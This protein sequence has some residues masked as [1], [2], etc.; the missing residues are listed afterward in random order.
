MAK[1]DLKLF[2]LRTVPEIGVW[3][4]AFFLF[5]MFYAAT[6]DGYVIT[7]YYTNLFNEHYAELIFIGWSWLTYTLN[8]LT[9]F[10]K[11]VVEAPYAP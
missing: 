10:I 3:A 7:G 2:V 9:D 1:L 6:F 4:S 5:A 8:K 11:K